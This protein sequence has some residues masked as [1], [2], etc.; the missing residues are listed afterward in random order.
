MRTSKPN[1]QV[2]DSNPYADDDLPESQGLV[3]S[4]PG[5]QGAANSNQTSN[6]DRNLH[7]GLER[8]EEFSSLD[9]VLGGKTATENVLGALDGLGF[10]GLETGNSGTRRAVD[11]EEAEDEV[12]E[13]DGE[14][15]GAEEGIEG[16]EEL[17]EEQIKAAF[18]SMDV[19]TRN[20]RESMHNPYLGSAGMAFETSTIG[21]T[22]LQQDDNMFDQ[23]ESSYP[24][25]AD[26]YSDEERGSRRVVHGMDAAKSQK[27]R[28]HRD[29]PLKIKYLFRNIFLLGPGYES[30][31]PAALILFALGVGYFST[32]VLGCEESRGLSNLV[33]F[34]ISWI[35][36]SI[37][38]T[39]FTNPGHLRRKLSQKEYHKHIVNGDFTCATC[40]TL[41]TDEAFHCEECGICV[42]GYDH[43]CVVMGNCV[44]RYNL[45][46]FYAMLFF[47]VSGI[48]CVYIVTILGLARCYNATPAKH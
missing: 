35:V 45:I 6:S 48:C 19:E 7:A 17:D 40:M 34:A 15:E 31:T 3:R 14:E 37:G 13:L 18:T 29:R 43:H 47:S 24:P 28:F 11:D 22:E 20:Q 21:G 12:Y 2:D 8:G 38:W 32:R 41:K 25:N 42:K 30:I 4:N 16:Q 44:G 10:R 46:P 1:H 36:L 39:A 9:D 27:P 23:D 33:K 26:D 5:N